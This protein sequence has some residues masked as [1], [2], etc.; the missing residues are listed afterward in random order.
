LIEEEVHPLSKLFLERKGFNSY[1]GVCMKKG[2]FGSGDVPVPTINANT[3]QIDH[4]GEKRENNQWV[5]L[6][7]EDKSSC[8]LSHI[9]EGFSRICFAIYYGGGDGLLSLPHDSF[10][11][12]MNNEEF[13]ELMAHVTVGKGRVG[14]LN[15]EKNK[16]VWF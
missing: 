12:A 2:E 15:I 16:E 11:I 6:W 13:F 3:V 9:L 1:K 8:K 14:L 7:I 4:Q 5:R 10:Q